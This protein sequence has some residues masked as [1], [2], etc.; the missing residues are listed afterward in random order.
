MIPTPLVTLNRACGLKQRRPRCRAVRVENRHFLWL[1]A[2]LVLAA[3]FLSSCDLSWLFGKKSAPSISSYS[4]TAAQN[5]GLSSDETAI[6]NGTDIYLT[7]P[8]L[9]AVDGVAVTPTVGLPSGSNISPS[10]TYVVKDNLAL[11]LSSG[12][13]TYNYTLHLGVD[14]ATIALPPF[15]QSFVVTQAQN[16]SVLTTD[17]DAV[18][19]GNGVYVTLPYSVITEEIPLTPTVQLASGYTITPTGSYPFINGATLEVTN[20]STSQLY[21]YKLYVAADPSTSPPLPPLETF[22]YLSTNNS[23]L[24]SNSVGVIEGQNVYTTLPYSALQ[25]QTPLTPTVTLAGGYTISPSGSY[26]PTDGQTLVVINTQTSQVLDYTLHVAVA[27]STI[28]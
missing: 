20:T 28:P 3:S 9:Y 5:P 2:S 26:V 23:L 24:S 13:G 21:D 7:L 19:Y 12:G 17:S 25:N 10:G 4:V 22:E 14:P 18:I 16:S 6:I 1:A 27:T 15:I 11:T 8:Y